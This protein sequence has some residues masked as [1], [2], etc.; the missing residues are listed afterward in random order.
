MKKIFLTQ[1]LLVIILLTASPVF[2]QAQSADVG[3]VQNF[4][5]SVIQVMVAVAGILAAVFFVIGGIRYITSTG[6]PDSLESAKKTIIFS[7][8]GLAIAFGA[9]VL[10]NI[11]QTLA[12]NAFGK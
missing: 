10:S 2:A 12:Q 11:V 5:T 6:S 1:S 9:L 3:K 8:V 7:A 4:L